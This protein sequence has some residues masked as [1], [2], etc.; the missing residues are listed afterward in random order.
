V[1]K[2]LLIISQTFVP[3]PA[4]VGQF[5]AD[6]AREMAGRG[7]NV[8]VYTQDRGYE[9]PT[10]RFP[11]RET[12]GGADVRRFRF[13]SF[14]KKSILTRLVGT[15]S[16][17]IQSFGG[18][19]FTPYLEGI[20]FSTS[21]PMIGMIAGLAGM[22]RRVP[23]VY[24]AMDLNPDQL[25][26]LGKLK[27]TDF[28]A[29]VIEGVNK[30]ILKRSSLII[31]LDRF[32][33][34]SLKKRWVPDAKLMVL[35]PWPHEEELLLP[36]PGG[37]R[38][39]VRGETSQV[40]DRELAE[41]S[42]SASL[43]HAAPLDEERFPPPPASPLRGE[44]QDANPFRVRHGL[45]GKFVVMYSGNHSPSNPLDTL[46]QATLSFKDDPDL[47]FLF[48]GG[49][50]GKKAIEQFVVDHALSNVICLPYQPLEELKH[51]LRA[52]DVHVVSLGD[53]M[54][55][56]VHPCKIYGAMAVG[57]PVLFLGPEPSH[58]ADLMKERDFGWRIVHGDVAG[59]VETLR[60]IRVASREE[61]TAKGERGKQLLADQL[62]QNRLLS[63]L[64]D[65]LE[66]TFGGA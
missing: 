8:R 14:G 66:Q 33:A 45:I 21:P 32:M 60:A 37:E 15:A 63:L 16:F 28:T 50:L 30:F 1:A 47:K 23:V 5:M 48:V 39:G 40:E 61:L 24:W 52:A 20:F 36:L 43:D 27:P 54:V 49:G 3:D 58:I 44:G 11:R 4:A 41:E 34:A 64:C 55:G 42:L 57:K 31:T 51:S 22:I 17:M 18:M 53:P 26:A 10:L 62:G 65:R 56:I 19:L 46:L 29:R 2:T 7:H 9:D 6:V 59:A 12:I 38:A 13:A 35:P 25:Y